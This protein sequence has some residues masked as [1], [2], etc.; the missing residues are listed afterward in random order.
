EGRAV[1]FPEKAARRSAESRG[2]GSLVPAPA[3]HIALRRDRPRRR[4]LLLL[5]GFLPAIRGHSEVDPRRQR[6]SEPLRAR[7][8]AGEL[9]GTQHQ[10]ARSGH[11]APGGPSCCN[12]GAL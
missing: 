1:R 10:P 9:P 6:G 12:P 2:Q 5:L 8:A 4:R 7:G 11:A 3:G